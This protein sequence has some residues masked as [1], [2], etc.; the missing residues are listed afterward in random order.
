MEPIYLLY[1][2]D[3]AVVGIDSLVHAWKT[4]KSRILGHPDFIFW[5]KKV[6]TDYSYF[7]CNVM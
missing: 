2:V 1:S 5:K 4:L 7:R 3:K 6:I